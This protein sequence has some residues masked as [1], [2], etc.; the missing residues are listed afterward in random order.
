VSEVPGYSRELRSRT[1]GQGHAVDLGAGVG[2]GADGQGRLP[3]AGRGR[4]DVD[5]HVGVVQVARLRPVGLVGLL[6]VLAGSPSGLRIA[7]DVS[8]GRLPYGVA[9]SSG[10]IS[11]LIVHQL[12]LL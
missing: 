5:R 3:A 11:Y 9:I 10:T 12:G 6:G 8:A 4:D 2:G 1:A 7:P